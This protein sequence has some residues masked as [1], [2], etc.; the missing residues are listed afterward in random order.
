MSEKI[1][2]HA[3]EMVRRIRDELADMLKDKSHP[4]II[5]FFKNAGD[6]AHKEYGDRRGNK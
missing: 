2:I 3:V 6:A 4:E 5:E 1:E